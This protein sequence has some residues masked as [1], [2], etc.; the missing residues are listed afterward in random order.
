MMIDSSQLF[1]WIRDR[2]NKSSDSLDQAI[3]SFTRSCAGYCVATFILGIGDRHPGN[4]MVIL[5]TLFLL[6][7]VFR[8]GRKGAPPILRKNK[9]KC[10][11]NK[12]EVPGFPV[13][14]PKL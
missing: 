5:L 1:K 14:E 2:N 12:H 4:I 3:H 11:F 7:P 6:S 9:N 10:V 8:G 13:P